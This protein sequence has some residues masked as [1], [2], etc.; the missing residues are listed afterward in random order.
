[1]HLRY[2]SLLGI[3]CLFLFSCSTEKDYFAEESPEALNERMQWW[4][5]ARFG[6]F[7]HW[8]PYAVPAGT[9]NG[10]KV[11]G[12]GEWIMEKA[13]IPVK[14]YESY[15]ADFNPEKFDAEEWVRIARD[16]GMKYIVIT[17]KHHDGFCL[18]DSEVSEYDFIDHSGFNRDVL[19][20]F[21]DACKAAGIKLGFYHSIM[22]WHHPDA[23]ASFYP[24]YNDD[25]RS[26]PG[27][28]QYVD[29][30]MRPQIK[31]LVEKYDP[32]ILWFDGEWI[33]DW[34][35]EQGVSLYNF[36]RNLK[37][38]IL[39]NNRV[40]KGRA[41]MQGMNKEDQAYAGD[42]GTPE[43]EILEG[44][45]T[46]DWES[47]MT[48][49]DTWGYKS[50][51]QNWKSAETLIHNLVDIVAKGGNYL[52]NVGPTAEGLIPGPSVD[53]LAEMG[54]W[55][56]VNGEAIYKGRLWNTYREGNKIRYTHPENSDFVYA[57]SLEWPGESLSLGAIRPEAGTDIYLL[58]Y[59]QP[60]RWSM[61]EDQR[62]RVTLPDALQPAD[63]RPCKYAYSFKIKGTYV[64][65]AASVELSINGEKLKELFVFT[66]ERR[67]AF[68]SE[69]DGANIY[70][71]LDGSIPDEQSMLYQGPI[72]ISD[73]VELKTVAFKEGLG[74]SS[75]STVTFIK[76]N[77]AG[78]KITQPYSDQYPASGPFALAD[79]LLATSDPLD[80]AWQG[81]QQ[82][83]VE[84][85]I[86]LGKIKTIRRINTRFLTASKDDI[87]PPSSLSYS[88]SKDKGNFK[89]VASWI[90]E[91]PEATESKAKII[92]FEKKLLL[93]R[94]RY[95][96]ISAQ[97]IGTIPAPYL[98]EG[99]PAWLFCDEIVVE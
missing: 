18:W 53:R 7:I 69:T 14:E 29:S 39:I 79:G 89:E 2:Y 17:S 99:N 46:L 45:S 90:P 77:V 22:D 72:L 61:D 98:G 5:D 51:D 88:I 85:V 71:T 58:G 84:V 75:L 35:H 8:G 13:A 23:H 63:N 49:N 87:L 80:P 37:P 48:M 33:K 73:P 55:M 28:D 78:L 83:P 4:R 82:G 91:R 64:E 47:C 12:I 38:E 10:K 11:D 21:A 54:D 9:H 34:K 94:A 36:V 67:V 76:A 24:K 42:F 25:D 26:S 96:K 3:L 65:T 31:E 74:R 62:L 6:M 95:I 59:D 60:L 56:R 50:Y 68:H 70:Y 66:D 19:Q 92:S 30:Y 20:E 93:R 32:A 86:D 41:G 40:D 57:I 52:L 1:M 44:T 15:A 81:Y 97:N 16:A 43:Q 27:F